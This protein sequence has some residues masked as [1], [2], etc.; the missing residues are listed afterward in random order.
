MTADFRILLIDNYDS[1]TYNLY[2]YFRQITDSDVVV[3]R[4]DSLQKNSP[5]HFSHIVISPGPGL[6]EEYP[7]IGEYLHTY[8]HE[9]Y[10]LGICLGLQCM[11]SAFGGSLKNL[12]HVL[13]GI[14][15]QVK[16]LGAF[17]EYEGL[18]RQIT[19]GHYHSWVADEKNLPDLFQI[20]SVNENGLIM[21]I[22]NKSGTLCG[23][24]FHP[25]SVMTPDGLRILS[26]WWKSTLI[27]A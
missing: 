27:S 1:Y 10:F 23:I 2:H 12:Q 8:G 13:H 14:T 18:S 26:N 6:P 5:E 7:L 9:K 17:P 20:T 11:T 24:Q 16:I 21:S 15:S 4:Y 25:E 19:V 3:M 22:R